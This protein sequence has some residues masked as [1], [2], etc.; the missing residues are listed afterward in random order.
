MGAELP[1]DDAGAELPAEEP[2]REKR[3]SLEKRL[4]LTKLLVGR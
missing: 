1:A 3:E 2:G 4:R